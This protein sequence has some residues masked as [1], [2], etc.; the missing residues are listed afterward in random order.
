[1]INQ[2]NELKL[3]ANS[4]SGKVLIEFLDDQIKQMTDITKMKTWEEVLGK[5]EAVRILKE[6]FSFLERAREKQPN[7]QRTDY[8]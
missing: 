7:T 6:L 3:L 4:D 2:P 5:Q 1:M 8:K